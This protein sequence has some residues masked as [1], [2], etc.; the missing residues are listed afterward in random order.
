MKEYLPNDIKNKIIQ[1]AES[2]PDYKDCNIIFRGEHCYSIVRV[3]AIHNLILIEGNEFTGLKHIEK[4]H[5][6]GFL[7]TWEGNK[8]KYGSRF[9]DNTIGVWDYAKIA[10][11]VYDIKNRIWE[12]DT[13][14]L[15]KYEA[16]VNVHNEYCKYRLLIHENTKII[17]NLF[18]L[19]T[20]PTRK[21]NYSPRVQ[22]SLDYF[23]SIKHVVIEF[24][25]KK[26]E[27]IYQVT[28]QIDF[29][30]KN[31]FIEIK[32]VIKNDVFWTGADPV[33]GFDTFF[34]LDTIFWDE[35]TFSFYKN[36]ILKYEECN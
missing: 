6:H 21:F 11:Q 2:N 29:V 33:M 28:L 18:P 31:S 12:T 13:N 7:F 4:G 32:N 9:P 27:A 19:K 5:G 8:L 36:E 26:K 16:F 1:D 34:T 10:D 24:L 25:N 15:E 35:N 3:S 14:G 23:K 22:I 30:K 17:H 20:K